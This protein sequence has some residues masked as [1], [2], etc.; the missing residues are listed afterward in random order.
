MS[1]YSD[2]LRDPRWQ[3][4]RLRV[5][6]THRWACEDCGGTKEQLE[7]HHCYYLR[8]NEP[9]EHGDNLLMCLCAH[10][11]QRRQ[12]LEEMAKQSLSEI[13]RL[14]PADELEFRAWNLCQQAAAM[15]NKKE[16]Q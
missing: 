6:D 8:G 1:Q 3:Q 15:K 11:H 7:V 9:W 10:C 5:L 4:R 12:N 14:L 2:K 13:L 16:S